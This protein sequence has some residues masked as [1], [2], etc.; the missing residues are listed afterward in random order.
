SRVSVLATWPAAF[1]FLGKK[2]DSNKMFNFVAC[3]EVVDCDNVVKDYK[4]VYEELYNPSDPNNPNSDTF[5]ALI[6]KYAFISEDEYTH[7]NAIWIQ[8]IHKLIF[9]EN[10]LLAKLDSDVVDT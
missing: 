4:K 8:A 3:A 10:Y 5:L 7:A 9:D 6:I 1:F 2:F